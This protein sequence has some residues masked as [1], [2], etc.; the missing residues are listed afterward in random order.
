MANNKI[1]GL[2]NVFKELYCSKTFILL[3]TNVW[4]ILTVELKKKKVFLLAKNT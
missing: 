2:E 4:N 1:F 3:A